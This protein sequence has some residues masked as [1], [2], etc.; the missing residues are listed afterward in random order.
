MTDFCKNC[1]QILEITK[2]VPAK[3]YGRESQLLDT[4]TPIELSETGNDISESEVDEIEEIDEIDENGEIT[5]IDEKFYENIIKKVEN[6]QFPSNDELSQIDV[7]KMIKTNYYRSLKTKSAIKKKLSD[8]IEDMGNSDENTSFM[9]FCSNCGYSR[10]LDPGF[11]ILSKQPEGQASVH[12]YSDD[13]KIRNSIHCGIY[14]RT[15]EFIC[16]NKDCL[17]HKP[18]NPTE[19]VFMRD[20]NTYRIIYVCTSCLTIK[21]L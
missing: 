12:D 19:A 11:H 5:D 9:L 13:S 16:P 14:P 2:S 10:P 4:E 18:N 7:K 8:M 6:N 17:S 15:R 20:G 1:D 21:R 3:Y